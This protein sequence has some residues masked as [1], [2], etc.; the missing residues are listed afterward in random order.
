MRIKTET[1]YR[2]WSQSRNRNRL[3]INMKNCISL[4]HGGREEG[5]QKSV[6]GLGFVGVEA[7]ILLHVMHSVQGRTHTQARTHTLRHTLTTHTLPRTRR[8][9]AYIDLHVNSLWLLRQCEGAVGREGVGTQHVAIC[10]M[11]SPNTN[12]PHP[13]PSSCRL[14]TRLPW[15]TSVPL[16]V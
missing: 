10:A 14:P 16:S 7:E 1:S 2:N 4:C 8:E 9:A 6:S 3:K 13:P 15:P 5:R 12:T 11:S